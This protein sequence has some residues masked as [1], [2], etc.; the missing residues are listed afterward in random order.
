MSNLV[1]AVAIKR[2]GKWGD[3]FSNVATARLM[4]QDGDE[5]WLVDFEMWGTSPNVDDMIVEPTVN[6]QIGWM[7]GAR[8]RVKR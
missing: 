3:V 7:E 2:D 8:W 1:T 6:K 4:M 5:L